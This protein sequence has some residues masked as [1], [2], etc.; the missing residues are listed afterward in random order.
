M[1]PSA[2]LAVLPP[3][4]LKQSLTRK[5]LHWLKPA[6]FPCR[7][8]AYFSKRLKF[9]PDAADTSVMR[10]CVDFLTLPPT[11][12][13]GKPAA[14]RGRKVSG[15]DQYFNVRD[16]GTAGYLRSRALSRSLVGQ[17]PIP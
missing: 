10:L 7:D 8:K 15:L 16:S 13:Q 9:F 17:L 3:P 14:R 4:V 1:F 11:T 5:S 6:T 2:V 12:E